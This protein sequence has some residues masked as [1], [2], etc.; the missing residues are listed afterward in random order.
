[1]YRVEEWK[2]IEWLQN[3]Y[4]VSNEGRVR[5]I[6]RIEKMKNGV[7]RPRKGRVLCQKT[8]LSG[9]KSVHISINGKAKDYLT[10]R[11]VALAFIPNPDSL[12]C[13]NHKD[14][15]K[16][17]NRVENLEWCTHQ[18]NISYK[19]NRDRAVATRGCRKVKKFSKDG[20][21]IEEY[22]S[23]CAAS[24]ANGLSNGNLHET[25]HNKQK[26]CGGF[27]WKYSDEG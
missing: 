3:I 24:R 2:P 11:L 5:S 23:C 18:Y 14:N 12:P 26:T 15:N 27:I 8:A 6:D 16:A 9:Y 22:R 17:N 21:F 13:I 10:H 4:E 19:G 1:M 20:V 25:L 7:M